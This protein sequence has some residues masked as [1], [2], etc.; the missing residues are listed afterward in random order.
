[1]ASH[2]PLDRPPSTL[3]R[4]SFD[5]S[6]GT[7]FRSYSGLLRVRPAAKPVESG[8]KAYLVPP[9]ST[10]SYPDCWVVRSQSS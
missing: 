5:T 7:L 4:T 8:S 3:L 9:S 2:S 1:M 6:F 10:L